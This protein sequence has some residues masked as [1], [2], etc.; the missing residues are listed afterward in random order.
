M[1]WLA[2]IAAGIS[3]AFGVMMIN[4]LHKARNVQSLL[5]LIFGFG[6][7]F[8]LLSYAMK[9]LPMGTAYAIWTGMG[10]T[11]GAL[12]GMLFYGESRD[13]RRILCIGVII[14]SVIGLKLIS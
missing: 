13:V 1:A 5:L 11:G 10:A 2:L 4:R 3:E 9:Y 6:A 8:L 7:S 14:A 12:V